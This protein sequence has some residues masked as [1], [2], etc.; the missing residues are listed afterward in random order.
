MIQYIHAVLRNALQHAVRQELV[1]RNVA[2]LV[3][4][5]APSYKTG[6]GLSAAM[7]KLVLK[8][9]HVQ[10]G[11]PYEP[12]NLRRSWNPVRKKFGLP[13]RFHDL[14]R[15]CITLLMDLGVPPHVVMQIAG[16]S[17][18]GVTMQVYA[19]VSLEE[20]RRALEKLNGELS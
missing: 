10:V 9:L 20:K 4:T 2:R 14:R 8:E 13:H 11:T 7:T 19:H 3:K 17:D 15:T 16:H 1:V 6:Q 5:P 12:D 18:Q